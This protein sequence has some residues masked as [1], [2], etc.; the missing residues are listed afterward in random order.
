MPRIKFPQGKQKIWIK[1]VL[2][3]ANIS[4]AEAAQICNISTKSFRDWQRGK[5]TISEKA[6]LRL[7]KKFN[8]PIPKDA[9]VLPDYWYITRAA[10][11]GALKRLQLYGPLGDKE[12]RRKGGLISQKR[13][14]ENPKKYQ[15]LGCSVRKNFQQLTKS[16][17]FA[18]AVGVILGDGGITNGQLKVYLG[19]K[20]DEEYAIFVRKLFEEVFGE[21]PAWYEYKNVIVLCL[22]GVGLIE[23]LK[24]WG[25][26]RGNKV[27]KQVDFP[28]WIWED[29]KF[30]IACVRGFMDTDGG[31]YHYRHQTKGIKYRHFA[32]CFKNS[33]EPLLSSTSKIL[34]KLMIRHTRHDKKIYIY[35]LKAVKEYFGIIGSNNPKH[36]RKLSYHLAKNNKLR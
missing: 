27:Q 1:R 23:D 35:S 3:K 34:D 21:L 10:R 18:E 16:E 15:L 24:K 14:R 4:V 25:L 29:I 2:K 28:Q 32:M 13:R 9:E 8:I 7:N 30:Q 6:A 19:K 33:S 22:S 20:A 5:L 11:K 17:L 31:V 12:S 26:L 36:E